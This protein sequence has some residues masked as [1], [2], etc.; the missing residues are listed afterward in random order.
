MFLKKALKFF[1][2]T[3]L[4]WLRYRKWLTQSSLGFLRWTLWELLRLL[5]QLLHRPFFNWQIDVIGSHSHVDDLPHNTVWRCQSARSSVHCPVFIL[6]LFCLFE[7]NIQ[8]H[9]IYTLKTGNV[10]TEVHELRHCTGLLFTL[11]AASTWV[12]SMDTKTN[13]LH[14]RYDED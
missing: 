12:H 14:R 11:H 5:T 6:N 9:W 10:S 1:Y 2:S 3:A 7:Y 8:V 4:L 13:R